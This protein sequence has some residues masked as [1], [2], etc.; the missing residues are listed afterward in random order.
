MA[1]VL[2]VSELQNYAAQAGFSKTTKDKQSGVSQL[3][4]IVAIA[5]GESGGNSQ[6]TN[7]KDPYHGSYGVLQINGSHMKDWYAT[8][9]TTK[10]CALDPACAFRYAYQLSSH[11]ANFNDW[12][13]YTNGSYK[14]HL[15]AAG[16]GI[17]SSGSQEQTPAQI[18][19]QNK[20]HVWWNDGISQTYTAGTELGTDYNTKLYTEIRAITPGKVVY[21]ISNNNAIGYVIGINTGDGLHHYQHL[22]SSPLKKGDTVTLGQVVGISGGCAPNCYGISDCTCKNMA[23]ST[24]PHIEVRWSP[25]YVASKGTEG[26]AYAPSDQHFKDIGGTPSGINSQ[27]PL[28][29]GGALSGFTSVQDSITTVTQNIH[30]APNDSIAAVLITLDQIMLIENPFTANGVPKL[31]GDNPLNFGSAFVQIGANIAG[32]V[33]AIVIRAALVFLGLFLFFQIFKKLV[34]SDA[35]DTAVTAGKVALA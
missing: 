35:I 24:G 25:T 18:F 7:L 33:I 26:Q 23:Y 1:K 17:G 4:T 8:G 11:G 31:L 20:W 5:L 30:L 9:T 3:Q 15:D 28:T 22:Q 29:T 16:M 2:T 32:D 6:S 21:A 10:A 12:G 27:P 19:N 13:A 34:F 14:S